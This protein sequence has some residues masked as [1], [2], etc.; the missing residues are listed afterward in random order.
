MLKDRKLAFSPYLHLPSKMRLPILTWVNLDKH[1]KKI[2][3]PQLM[4]CL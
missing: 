4:D 3:L 2:D 1:K